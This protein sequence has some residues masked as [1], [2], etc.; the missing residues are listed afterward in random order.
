MTVTNIQVA[1]K[2]ASRA[3][4][5]SGKQKTGHEVAG[6]AR[7][8]TEAEDRKCSGKRATLLQRDLHKRDMSRAGHSGSKGVLDGKCSLDFSW[9]EKHIERASIPL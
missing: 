6:A 2:Q 8:K 9:L 7:G 4:M 3:E 5:R 1:Y